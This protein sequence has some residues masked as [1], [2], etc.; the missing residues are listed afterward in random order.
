MLQRSFAVFLLGT[1]IVPAGLAGVK[2]SARPAPVI[3]DA[4]AK[5]SLSSG[6]R[7]AARLKSAAVRISF[8]PGAFSLGVSRSLKRPIL[9]E[10][11]AKIYK[12]FR[13]FL[14]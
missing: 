11:S 6:S 7:E 5:K 13:V 12:F 14:I 4:N 1:C 2:H 9:D 3:V 8:Q 10:K